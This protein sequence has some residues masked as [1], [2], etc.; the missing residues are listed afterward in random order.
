MRGPRGGSALVAH[1]GGE[2]PHGGGVAFCHIERETK[3]RQSM[4]AHGVKSSKGPFMTPS[5]RGQTNFKVCRWVVLGIVT[6]VFILC[7]AW[8]ILTE[9]DWAL[10]MAERILRA[11]GGRRDVRNHGQNL[12]GR[13]DGGLGVDNVAVQLNG[14][15]GDD[16]GKKWFGLENSSMNYAPPFYLSKEEEI[17]PAL[18]GWLVSSSGVCSMRG[19]P[20]VRQRKFSRSIIGGRPCEVW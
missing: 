12:G 14:A 2:D 20:W 5:R 8:E 11:M 18:C 7:R 1:G 17:F 6:L 10:A 15:R 3:G 13:G 19:W 9:E 16:P 4:K